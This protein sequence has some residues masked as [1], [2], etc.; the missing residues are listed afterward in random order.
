MTVN[1]ESESWDWVSEW[2]VWNKIKSQQRDNVQIF[3]Y[4]ITGSIESI[5]DCIF[6]VAKWT[7]NACNREIISISIKW[8]AWVVPCLTVGSATFY[9][10][11]KS[12]EVAADYIIKY[13]FNLVPAHFTLGR[14]IN[15]QKQIIRNS[16]H[17]SSTNRQIWCYSVSW[18]MLFR[19][20]R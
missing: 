15:F 10:L 6:S 20:K 16:E 18:N 1:N 2:R 19:W 17:L 12:E 14:L 4:F 13:N 3:K 11:K 8:P 5:K 9:I 7:L